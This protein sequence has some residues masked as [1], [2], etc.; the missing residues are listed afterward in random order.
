M[1]LF[2]GRQTNLR[3]LGALRGN[4]FRAG[5]TAELQ[6][7]ATESTEDTEKTGNRMTIG[8]YSGCGS[9]ALGS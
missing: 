9:A 3:D 6:E 4:L 7:R 8:G 5:R 1:R 2:A